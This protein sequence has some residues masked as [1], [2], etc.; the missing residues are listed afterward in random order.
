MVSRTNAR[1]TRLI[2]SAK[3]DPA[4]ASPLTLPIY[5][6]T[7]FVFDDTADLIDYNE[8][9]S[10]KYLYSR[11]SNPTVAAV[12]TALAALDGAEQAVLFS[13]GMAA[14]TATLMTH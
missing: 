6:T 1:S 11:Y 2:H 3:P 12:E 4:S 8:G 13:S 5:E 9:R 7:T 10:A 14:V